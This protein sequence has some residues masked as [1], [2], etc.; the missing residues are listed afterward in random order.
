MEERAEK[1][2]RKKK[3]KKCRRRRREVAAKNWRL[4]V[5]GREGRRSH[6]RLLLLY[7]QSHV[8]GAEFKN[9]TPSRVAYAAGTLKVAR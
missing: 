5:P 2:K 3:E 4:V 8:G 9:K 7:I 1:K 6:S